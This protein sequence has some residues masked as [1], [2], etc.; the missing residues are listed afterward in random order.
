MSTT[1]VGPQSGDWQWFNVNDYCGLSAAQPARRCVTIASL[2][3]DSKA[4]IQGRA[5]G[6]KHGGPGYACF[7][8]PTE[9]RRRAAGTIQG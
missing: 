7:S 9:A 3:L 6:Q 2:S 1:T 5:G 8:G 4:Q